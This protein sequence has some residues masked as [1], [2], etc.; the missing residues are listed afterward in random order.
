[1]DTEL[2]RDLLQANRQV[3]D[4]LAEQVQARAHE[5]I[6]QTM[7][8]AAVWADGLGLPDADT[9]LEAE[10]E[11]RRRITTIRTMAMSEIR[12]LLRELQLRAKGIR[13]FVERRSGPAQDP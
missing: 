7:L 1:M 5:A 2:L 9:L 6:E 10:R 11:T 3:F 13:A 4:E 8:D 12:L